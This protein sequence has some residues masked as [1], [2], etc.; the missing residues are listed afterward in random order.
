MEFG[1]SVILLIIGKRQCVND[2]SVSW[3]VGGSGVHSESASADGFHQLSVSRT[4]LLEVAI[5][6]SN[7]NCMKSSAVYTSKL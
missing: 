1:D 4:G 5:V 3:S 7:S 2:T 6:F